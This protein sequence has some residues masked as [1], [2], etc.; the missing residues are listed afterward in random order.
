MNYELKYKEALQAAG[1]TE[2]DLLPKL[3]QQISDIENLQSAYDNAD[4]DEKEDIEAAIE[5]LDSDLCKKIPKNQQMKEKVAKMQSARGKNKQVVTE[6][7]NE[8]KIEE[9]KVKVEGTK[10]KEVDSDENGS[11]S[12]G[13][14]LGIAA[15]IVGVAFVGKWQKWF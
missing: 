12:S 3:K 5:G 8:P 4:E 10:E 13:W 2:N 15:S 6:V 14:I 9:P 7:V 1:I 11:K